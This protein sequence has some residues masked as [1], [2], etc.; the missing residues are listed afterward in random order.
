V[1]ARFERVLHERAGAW[2]GEAHV[3]RSAAFGDL[4]ADGDV[5]VVVGERNG[6]LR[7]LAND[8]A[9][10]PYLIVELVDRRPRVGNRHGYGSRIT[11][12]QG[13][14]RQTRWVFSGGS[15]QSASAPYA[16]FGLA[17]PDEVALEIAWSDGHVQR[18]PR[19]KPGQHLK[20]ERR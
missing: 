20:V 6:P 13:A 14:A 2:L 8:G 17:S 5:D 9:R 18:L 19:V 1:G 3:D 15:F 16:H 4:D 11:L 10:G 12:R 7:L